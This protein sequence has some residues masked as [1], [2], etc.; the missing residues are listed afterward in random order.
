MRHGLGVGDELLNDAQ[1]YARCTRNQITE[2]A[3]ISL[4][5]QVSTAV[6]AI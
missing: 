6:N 1:P 4:L 5:V 3:R 2:N